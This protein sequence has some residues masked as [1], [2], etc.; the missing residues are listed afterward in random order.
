MSTDPPG[1]PE[2]LA[3]KDVTKTSCKLTWDAPKSDGGSKI[4][5]YYVEKLSGTRWSRVTKKAITERAYSVS[6][7]IEG[8]E[9]EFRVCAENAAGVGE[10]S[11]T[12]GKFVAKNPFD[13]PGRPDAPSI[14]ELTADSATVAYKAPASDGGSPITGYI[15]EMKSKLDSKWKVAGK[16]IKETEFV[17]DGLKEGTE[18][19]FRVTAENKAGQS[20]PSLP[21][22]PVKY[23][24]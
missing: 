8:S 14:K 12:T 9:N 21:S 7:L 24:N 23:G 4:I 2:N 3:V 1:P 13:V 6:D 16:D 19:E 18:Y 5:G 17:V 11:E 10:P 20:Q 15:V 22:K